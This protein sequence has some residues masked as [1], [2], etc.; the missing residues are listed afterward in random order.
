ML[1]RK[2]ARR[3]SHSGEIV[4]VFVGFLRQALACG[5]TKPGACAAL[6]ACAAVF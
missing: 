4:F 2:R 1:S 6:T 3:Q 5:A